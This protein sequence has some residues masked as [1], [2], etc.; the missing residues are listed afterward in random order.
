MIKIKYFKIVKFE[1]LH[2]EINRQFGP[3]LMSMNHQI[4]LETRNHAL[5]FMRENG[6]NIDDE[7]EWITWDNK[8]DYMLSLLK[9]S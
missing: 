5:Q 8:K 9:W 6:F 2:E 7:I 4:R 1:R 3:G